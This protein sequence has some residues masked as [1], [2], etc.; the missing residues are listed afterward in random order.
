MMTSFIANRVQKT[1]SYEALF[2]WVDCELGDMYYSRR[3]GQ[4]ATNLLLELRGVL[5]TS[6][7]ATILVQ[8]FYQLLPALEKSHYLLG[9]RIRQWIGMNYTIQVRDPLERASVA[10]Y[11]IELSCKNL[12]SYRK[13]FFE[14]NDYEIPYHDIQISVGLKRNAA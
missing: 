8:K 12:D 1:S 11:E 5:S 13:S 7:S 10:E 4:E 9:Y 3:E 14:A 6:Q 2:R